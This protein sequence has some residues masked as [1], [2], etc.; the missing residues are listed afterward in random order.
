M[1][2]YKQILFIFCFS[3]LFLIAQQDVS[4]SVGSEK[5]ENILKGI[6]TI[7]EINSICKVKLIDKRLYDQNKVDLNKINQYIL[8]SFTNTE[9]DIDLEDDIETIKNNSQIKPVIVTVLVEYLNYFQSNYDNL[10]LKAIIKVQ[11]ERG[12]FLTSNSSFDVTSEINL[13]KNKV[14]QLSKPKY[15]EVFNKAEDEL[16]NKV[17]EQFA[18]NLKQKLKESIIKLYRVV[19]YGKAK[20]EEKNMEKTKALAVNNALIGATTKVF[21]FKISSETSIVDM[22]AVTDV[23]NQ[24]T[25]GRIVEYSI[26]NTFNKSTNDGYYFTVVKSILK[27]N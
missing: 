9:F 27:S 22:G 6:E 8:K 15:Q 16:L 12:S 20:L 17:N 23:V 14:Q 10:Y 4:N 13:P 2:L 5:Y 3:P 11:I 1:N 21:G 26:D 7:S 19:T 18:N 24:T 25:E